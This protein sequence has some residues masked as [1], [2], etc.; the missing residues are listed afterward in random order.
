MFA[1]PAMADDVSVSIGIN[2]PGFYGQLNIGEFPHPQV[3][4]PRPIVIQQEPAYRDAEPLYLH[5]PRGHEKHWSKHCA[6]YHA[7]GR[8]V[9]FV[10]DDWYKQEYERR[11]RQD[12]DEQ[13]DDR[14]ERHHHGNKHDHEDGEH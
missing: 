3:V 5:V 13:G 4:Y 7:C 14:R 11:H 1:A 12:N 10:R 8:P 9:Y 6:T 2:R